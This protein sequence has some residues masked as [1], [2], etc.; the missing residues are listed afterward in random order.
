MRFAGHEDAG[1]GG[2]QWYADN[3]QCWEWED[4]LPASHCCACGGGSD[5]WDDYDDYDYGYDD[6][7]PLP[8]GDMT[9]NLGPLT[10][11]YDSSASKVVASMGAAALA[12]ALLN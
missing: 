10:I 5:G 8:D 3:G 6:D 11:D 2:C 9:W 1:Y 7:I 4:W 12:V